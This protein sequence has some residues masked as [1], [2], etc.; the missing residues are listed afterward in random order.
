M[1]GSYAAVLITALIIVAAFAVMIISRKRAEKREFIRNV[2]DSWGR[3]KP[4]LFLAQEM[5]SIREYSDTQSPDGSFCVVDDTT[6]GDVDLD[7]VFAS[8]CG[9]LSSPGE[10]VLYSWL[11]HPLTGGDELAERIRMEDFFAAHEEERMGILMSLS[12]IGHMKG[13]SFCHYIRQIRYAEP[14]G[15]NRFIA[16]GLLTAAAFVLLFFWPLAAILMLI[17]ILIADFRVHMSM[18]KMTEAPIR[19]FQA[20]IRLIRGA[21][22]LASVL[23]DTLSAEKERLKEL[24]AKCAE[25]RRGSTLVT[26]G[27]SVGTGIDDAILEYLKMLFH[28]DYIRFDSMLESALKHEQEIMELLGLIGG[29]DAACAAASWKE[30]QKTCVRPVFRDASGKAELKVE[31]LI[32]PLLTEAVPNSLETGRP[33]LLTGSNASGKS[34]FLKSIALSAI[35]AQSIGAVT[36]SSYEAPFFRIFSSM[37]LSDNLAGGESYFIVEIRSLK[38]IY[39]AAETAFPPVLALVDEILRGTNTIERI[40][41]SS[42]VLTE[43]GRKNALIFAATHDMELSYLLEDSYRNLH[44]Q[45][46]AK[47]GDV[48][49]DYLLKEGRAESGNALKL[50][51]MN[52]YPERVTERAGEAVRHFEKTGEWI[53]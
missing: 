5:E 26:S 34:T 18:K 16:L 37:A 7:R 4:R 25:V 1:Y 51:A 50:L 45:E 14:V 20:V 15:R 13:G 9:A 6:A 28:I 41:A 17:P 52:G 39:D 36:A 38:R 33:V 30:A 12:R 23:P 44:F 40:A 32:H 49:F 3:G 8:V 21:E 42:Q 2:K 48:Q 27:G 24:A 19:G 31:G 53:L 43:L 47:D 11:R 22:D 29:I 35:L 46:S 10:E